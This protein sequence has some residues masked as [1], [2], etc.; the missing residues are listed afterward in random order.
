MCYIVKVDYLC[1]VNSLFRIFS[2]IKF[3]VA[4]HIEKYKIISIHLDVIYRYYI[5][6]QEI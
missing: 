5:L 1:V 6:D 4:Y 2:F 3:L